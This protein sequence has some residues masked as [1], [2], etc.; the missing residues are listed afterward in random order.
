MN[1]LESF[2]CL[3]NSNVIN[4]NSGIDLE[5]R[6]RVAVKCLKKQF[7]CSVGKIQYADAKQK[8]KN[9]EIIHEGR[10]MLQMQELVRN[11]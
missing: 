7:T 3:N 4:Y 2:G 1:V 9:L 8:K 10:M 6:E 5:T 11:Y